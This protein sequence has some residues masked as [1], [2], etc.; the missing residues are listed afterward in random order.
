[1][2]QAPTPRPRRALLLA[3]ALG[4][5][6]PG[7]AVVDKAADLT[8]RI[9]GRHP[10]LETLQPVAGKFGFT[11]QINPNGGFPRYLLQRDFYRL[12]LVV[13]A[14]LEK[15]PIKL[16]TL[17]SVPINMGADGKVLMDAGTHAAL[18]KAGLT[19]PQ[20]TELVALINELSKALS[21]LAG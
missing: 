5:V 19:R 21:E 3:L 7:C 18:M 4:A 2:V 13:G 12:P 11:A 20:I 14:N 17:A 8:H 16:V 6:A 10:Q 15:E 1:M 9:T